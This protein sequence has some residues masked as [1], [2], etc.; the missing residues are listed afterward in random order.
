MGFWQKVEHPA[1]PTTTDYVE[2]D[3]KVA[4]DEHEEKNGLGLD[5]ESNE[6]QAHHV[7]PD[8]ERR[9]VRKMDLRVVPLVSALCLLFSVP[10]VLRDHTLMIA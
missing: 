4:R 8:L 1:P 5:V 2:E 3:R 7:H 9:V 10:Q 6:C